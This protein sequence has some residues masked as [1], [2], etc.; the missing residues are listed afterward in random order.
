MIAESKIDE[1]LEVSY[2]RKRKNKTAKVVIERLKEQVTEE[3][4]ERRKQAEADADRVAYG[5]AIEAL[6]DETRKKYRVGDEVKGVR[7]V[8]VEKRA[9]ASGKI[10]TGDIIEEVGFE[11]VTSPKEFE[12][13]MDAAKKFDAPVT[14]LINRGGNYIF[15]ALSV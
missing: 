11:V 3:E 10:L 5:I 14:L 7:V 12:E 6:T 15:Y 13:A 4:K 1:T 8:K 9:E 2:I